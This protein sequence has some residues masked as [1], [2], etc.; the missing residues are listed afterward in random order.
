M[1]RELVKNVVVAGT[2]E[3]IFKA[4]TTNEGVRAFFAPSSNV[5]LRVG[6][7]FEIYFQ[8]GW[9]TGEEWDKGYDYFDRA[10]GMVIDNL[11]KHFANR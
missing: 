5:E 8:P 11:V 3:E 7:P 2:P 10:W 9:K 1:D 6:G 4:W